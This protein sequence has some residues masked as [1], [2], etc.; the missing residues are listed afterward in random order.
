MCVHDYNFVH[1]LFLDGLS[2]DIEYIS[3]CYRGGPCCLSIR[4]S[5]HLLI[6]NSRSYPLLTNPLGNQQS[7]LYVPDF[8]LT[9]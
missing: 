3:L 7:I 9:S 5:L 1:P 2:Q 4:T 6:P 8:A